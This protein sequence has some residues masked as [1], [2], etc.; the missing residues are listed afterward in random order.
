MKNEYLCPYCRGNL[1]IENDI[2]FA[3]RTKSEQRGI[4]LLSPKLGNY[5]VRKHPDLK[6]EEGEQ[7]EIFCPM[8][9]SNLK[10]ININENLAEVLMIDELG[11]EYEIYFSEIVGEHVTFK[12]HDSNVESF[13]DDTDNYM[14]YFGA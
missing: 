5:R 9:H 3:A 12:I 11:D 1:K 14:N 6:F 8:C 10:A 13:G 7:L 2:I 4:I